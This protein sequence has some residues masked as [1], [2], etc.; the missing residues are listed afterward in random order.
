MANKNI[1]KNESCEEL[2]KVT[3]EHVGPLSPFCR[4]G[5]KVASIQDETKTVPEGICPINRLWCTAYSEP[6][7]QT[8]ASR[9]DD[10]IERDFI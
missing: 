1:I 9:I 4:R 5:V 8:L 7:A 6:V 10:V 3:M 2:A